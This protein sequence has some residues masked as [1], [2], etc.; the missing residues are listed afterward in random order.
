MEWMRERLLFRKERKKKNRPGI[1]APLKL[2]PLREQ[3]NLEI[4][5]NTNRKPETMA[6]RSVDIFEKAAAI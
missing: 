5:H 3:L 2:L 1:L 6:D 4:R